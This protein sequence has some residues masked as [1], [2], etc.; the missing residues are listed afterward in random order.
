MND[1][2]RSV[3]SALESGPV[4]GPELAERL[5]VS[6]AAVWKQ[7]D[8]LREDG[9]EIEPS[10]AGYVVRSVPAYGGA[11]IEFGLDCPYRIE[12]HDSISSTNDRGRELATAGERDVAVVADEQTASRGRRG[13]TWTAPRGGIWCSVVCQPTLPPA[14]VPIATLAAGVATVEACQSVGVDAVLKWP[15]DVL[16]TADSD[17]VDADADSDRVDVDASDSTRV[18]ADA[19]SDPSTEQ[20]RGGQKLAGILTEMEGEA[21]RVS[22]LL[23]GVGI[24]ANIDSD[25]LPPGATSLREQGGDVDRRTVVQELLCRLS[26]L[27]SEP[28]T[29][30]SRWRTHATTLGQRVRVDTGRELIDGTAVDVRY[31]GALVI[32]TDSGERVVHAGDC[33]HLR[34]VSTHSTDP[35]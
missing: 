17:R 28:D 33:E 26:T 3:L 35:N 12:Y 27:L 1:T 31:P 18:N 20:G 24:N 5:G 16:V 21:D 22:W 30:L 34:P 4:S 10:P 7:V 14:R 23:L 11:A 6:R 13:R 2:R 8:S 29:V 19:D 32:E 15:N 25:S 9:F